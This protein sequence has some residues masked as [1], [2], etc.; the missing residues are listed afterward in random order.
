MTIEDCEFDKVPDSS[1]EGEFQGKSKSRIP[2]KKKFTIV[3]IRLSIQVEVP[4]I[5]NNN[6]EDKPMIMLTIINKI[7]ASFAHFSLSARHQPRGIIIKK[8]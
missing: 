2:R 7:A 3:Q 8:E 4:S 6:I 5:P 1:T